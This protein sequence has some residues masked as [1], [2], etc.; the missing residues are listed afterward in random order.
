LMKEFYIVSGVAA[1][2]GDWA[3]M[4]PRNWGRIGGH[5]RWSYATL[6]NFTD[7]IHDLLEKEGRFPGNLE[8]RADHY[9]GRAKAI[10]HKTLALVQGWPDL[11][12][13]P[14]DG[15]SQC[16][17]N[18]MCNWVVERTPDAWHCYW[19]LG[20]AEH[21]QDCVDRSQIWNPLVIPFEPPEEEFPPG[22]PI[23]PD[24]EREFLGFLHRKSEEFFHE[25]G[26]LPTERGKEGWADPKAWFKEWKGNPAGVHDWDC[27]VHLA[28]R[29]W[30]SIKRVWARGEIIDAHEAFDFATL[31][32]ETLHTI[33][34]IAPRLYGVSFY[35]LM[36]EALTEEVKGGLFLPFVEALG[37]KTKVR[38]VPKVYTRERLY[39]KDMLRMISRGKFI[40]EEMM[41]E[42]KFF[43]PPGDRL[44]RLART[45]E[46][47]WPE[48]TERAIARF[49]LEARKGKGR[50][51]LNALM[52]AFE[53]RYKR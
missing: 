33:N 8:M 28:P 21:C 43:T 16:L 4:T 30:D 18:C 34:P 15:S 6:G 25:R 27:K 49:F 7:D 39:L 46:T 11:P 53:R 36:E 19:T 12:A 48:F 37:L 42:L 35:R 2:G 52:R 14:G 45:L 40:E 17:S 22:S 44:L 47:L 31:L 10:F 41:F 24:K 1:K 13:Y 29:I 23:P 20:L 50:E 9:R 3:A 51:F 26:F 32:H 5:L 38:E